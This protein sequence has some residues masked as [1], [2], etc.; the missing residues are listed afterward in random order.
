MMGEMLEFEVE[1]DRAC[2]AV[3]HHVFHVVVEDFGR[4]PA[5]IAEGVGM[6]IHEG[7][8]GAA[9]DILDIHGPGK[10]QDHGKGMHRFGASVRVADLIIAEINLGLQA[11]FRFEADIRQATALFLE[12]PDTISQGGVAAGV[13]HSLEPVEDPGHLVVVLGDKVLD[14]LAE[15]V[16]YRGA[17]LVLDV[18]RNVPGLEVLF[19]GVA[20]DPQ[21]PG[22]G[23]L[24]ETLSM[25]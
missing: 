2:L 17:A 15:G 21:F 12:R 5:Q 6:A 16:E 23:P 1:P 9:F 8:Q 3:E 19:D 25:Q 11:R 13:A 14:D 10:T 18:F 4:H 24:T 20:V 7:F 22:Y